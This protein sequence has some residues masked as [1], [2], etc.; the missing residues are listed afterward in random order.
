MFTIFWTCTQTSLIIARLMKD[1]RGYTMTLE[2]REYETQGHMRHKEIN[3]LYE[4]KSHIFFIGITV[5]IP[6]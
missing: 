6:Y 3:R 4:D 5:Y 1:I 2:T